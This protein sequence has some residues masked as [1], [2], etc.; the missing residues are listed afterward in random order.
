MK[1]IDKKK[2]TRKVSK[3]LMLNGTPTREKAHEIF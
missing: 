3:K 1:T 2:K